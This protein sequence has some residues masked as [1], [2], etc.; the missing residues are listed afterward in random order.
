[1]NLKIIYIYIL[2]IYYAPGCIL[3]TKCTQANP[4]EPT[5]PTG[6]WAYRHNP[7][8]IDPSGRSQPSLF[9]SFHLVTKS[10]YLIIHREIDTEATLGPRRVPPPVAM[11][12]MRNLGRASVRAGSGG[13]RPKQS[14]SPGSVAL[15]SFQVP[16]GQL[17]APVVG[18]LG[19]NDL[20]YGQRWCVD[21][22]ATSQRRAAMGP[23]G[24]AHPHARQLES[25][26][27]SRAS[28]RRSRCAC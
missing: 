20:R 7:R 17:A 28:G 11:E 1:M 16:T 26:V 27:A 23:L 21:P 4:V 12:C 19:H 9:I 14:P 6:D 22:K 8:R 24:A 25:A 3:C 2:Y 13:V 5:A 15:R 10:K 18:A